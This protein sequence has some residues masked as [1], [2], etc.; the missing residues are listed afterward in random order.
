LPAERVLPA[1]ERRGGDLD[2]PVGGLAEN[3][4]DDNGRENLRGLAELLTVNQEIAESFGG[5]HELGRDH[6]HPAKAKANPQRDDIGRQ[7]GRQQDASDHCR[8]RQA[9]GAADLDDLAVHREDRAEHAEINRE[10]HADRDQRDFRGFED[11]EP[12]DE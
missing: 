4:E 2:Q 10:E 12:Q 5:A 8:S 1:Q 11:A 6:K 9:E 7:H 3:R